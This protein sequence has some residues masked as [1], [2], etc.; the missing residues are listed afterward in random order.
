MKVEE[1]RRQDMWVLGRKPS[2]PD[3]DLDS[4][5]RKEGRKPS[6]AVRAAEQCGS[7]K[8]WARQP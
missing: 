4:H 1:G 2:D 3:P 6:W 7:D 8:V 5:A